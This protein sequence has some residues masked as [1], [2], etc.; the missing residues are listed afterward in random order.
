M[1]FGMQPN[2]LEYGLVL[3][4]LQAQGAKPSCHILYSIGIGDLHRDDAKKIQND[5]WM[6]HVRFAAHDPMVQ[7]ENVDILTADVQSRD[8]L[9]HVDGVYCVDVFGKTDSLPKLEK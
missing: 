3:L 6:R 5:P 1:F 2:E 7:I 8:L 9:S 4:W